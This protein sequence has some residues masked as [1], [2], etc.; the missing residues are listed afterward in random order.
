MDEKEIGLNNSLISP[1][2]FD[3]TQDLKNDAIKEAVAI[4]IPKDKQEI[5]NKFFS[6]SKTVA[7]ANFDKEE[8]QKIELKLYVAELYD[9]INMPRYKHNFEIERDLKNMEILF[10]ANISKAK[11]G[12]LLELFFKSFHIQQ[13]VANQ[14]NTSRGILGKLKFW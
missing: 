12:K 9:F 1:S 4:D 14:E 11:S 8:I 3:K 10:K 5:K 2:F 7:T 6:L 13:L